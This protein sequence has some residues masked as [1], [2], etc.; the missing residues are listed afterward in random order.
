MSQGSRSSLR[1]AGGAGGIYESETLR[2]QREVDVF[3]QKLEHEKRRLL[4]IEEQIKQVDSE[5]SER[6]KSMQ[7]MKPS[8]QEERKTS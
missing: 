7:S 6:D 2:L 5:L 8:F 4:I 3:T 1:T